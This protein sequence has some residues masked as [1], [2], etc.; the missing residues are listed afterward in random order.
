MEFIIILVICS[1]GAVNTFYYLCIDLSMAMLKNKISTTGI[2]V[3]TVV[4]LT[5]EAY[6]EAF[7]NYLMIDNTSKTVFFVHFVKLTSSL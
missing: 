5:N 7:Q 6:L 3:R 1:N 4:D 2:N